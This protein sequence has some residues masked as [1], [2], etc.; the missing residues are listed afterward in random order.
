MHATLCFFELCGSSLQN[1]MYQR[2]VIEYGCKFVQEVKNGCILWKYV[3][4]I[5]VDPHFEEVKFAGI[6]EASRR[7][8][9]QRNLEGKKMGISRRDVRGMVSP[10][11]QILDWW[12]Q[13]NVIHPKICHRE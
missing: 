3:G 7:H 5:A 11:C 10:G 4:Y 9:Y 1:H 6:K 12:K 8:I 13:K 2:I